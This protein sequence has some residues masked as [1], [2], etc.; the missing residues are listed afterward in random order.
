MK[1]ILL[2]WGAILGLTCMLSA[3]ETVELTLDVFVTAV[4]ANGGIYD[5]AETHPGK[6]VTVAIDPATVTGAPSRVERGGKYP[7]YAYSVQYPRFET[8]ETI[9]ISNVTFVFKTTQ[10]TYTLLNEK[11]DAGVL[12]G[13]LQ[14]LVANAN[15]T[16]TLTNCLFDDVAVSVYGISGS[17]GGLASFT[18]TGCTFKNTGGSAYALKDVN[19]TG[20]GSSVSITGCVFDNVPSGGILLN[21]AAETIA[22][23]DN[24][25]SGVTGAS[26]KEDAAIQFAKGVDFSN[27]TFAIKGNT[28][29]GGAFL[30]LDAQLPS[31]ALQTIIAGNT[32]EK[33]YT[34][35]S[36]PGAWA[37][38]SVT[39][40]YDEAK[41]AYEISSPEELAGLA[42][43]VNA[44]NTFKGKTVNLKASIDLGG[45]EWTPIGNGTRLATLA[46]GGKFEG[47]FN[48]GYKTIS[49]LTITQGQA[50]SSV[51]LF[52]NLS[53]GTVK[54]LYLENVAIDVP[55]EQVG[56]AVGLLVNGATVQSV[57]VRSGSVK[58]AE[59]TGGIVGRMV[60][61]GTVASCTN[62]GAAVSSGKN[63]GG[64]V[65]AAYYD[66]KGMAVKSCTNKG[67]VTGGVC[68]GGIV[69]F[70]VADVESCANSGAV[71]GSGNG[72]GGIVGEQQNAGSV[73]GS[74]N[75]GA[76]KGTAYVGG[77]VGW[78]R[79][80]GADSA[81]P[82][83]TAVAVTGNANSGA[84]E[85]SG[86]SVGGIVGSLYE[87][88]TVSGNT[89]TAAT[90]SGSGNVAGLVG[91]IYNGAEET[92][93]LGNYSTTS[94]LAFVNGAGKRVTLN[95]SSAAGDDIEVAS[96][97][98]LKAFR[99]LVNVGV[100]FAGK[101]VT[102]TAD[103]DLGNEEWK[104]IGKTGASFRGTF[105][106]NGK[107]VSNLET[108]DETLTNAGLFG[109]MDAPAAIKGLTVRNA[110]VSGKASVGALIGCA[111]TG[112][113]EDCHVAGAVSVTG[114]YK[115]GGL[116]G[117]GYADIVG[118][119][120]KGTAKAPITVT[121]SFLAADFEGDNVG[122]LVGFRGEG[123]GI[124]TI[125]CEVAY[126]TASG[127]RKVGGLIGSAFQDNVVR[128]GSVAN[129]TVVCNATQTYAQD[130][131]KT[132]GFG[133]LVG[134]YTAS[135]SNDGELAGCS[136]S[137]V[138][139]D[140]PAYADGVEPSM[141]VL[142][143]G[144]RGTDN[145]LP[146]AD[147]LAV[148]DNT[149][150]GTN[151]GANNGYL[152][153]YVAAIG[154]RKYLSLLD[155]LSAAKAG[156]T[157][158]VLADVT[159]PALSKDEAETSG[160]RDI[161]I[162]G[163]T[164]D[165]NGKAVTCPHMAF[166]LCGTDFT[167]KNGTLIAG[168]GANYALFIGGEPTT[169]NVTV[170]AVSMQGG[171][172]IYN[173]AGVT[174]RGGQATVAAQK[175]YAVW[176]DNDVSDVT[177]E[178]GF[179]VAA[180]EG[181]GEGLVVRVSDAYAGAES[182]IR[183]AGGSYSVRPDDR[184]C[185][186]AEGFV[187][188]PNADGTYRVDEGEYAAQVGDV[189]Y[190]TL[191][192]AMDAA[193]AAEPAPTVTLL[194]DVA[195]EGPVTLTAD[196]TLDLAGH[197]LYAKDGETPAFTADSEVTLTM[198]P[199][200]GGKLIAAAQ[201]KDATKV[202]ISG[203]E[204]VAATKWTDEGAYDEAYHA[205][206]QKMYEEGETF[207]DP[208]AP[209]TIATAGELAALCRFSN[210][211]N[212]EGEQVSMA[213]TADID[214]AG[215][216]WEPI[217]AF[218]GTFDGRTFTIANMA[219]KDAETNGGLFGTLEG[220][221]YGLRLKGASVS[222]KEG[223]ISGRYYTLRGGT[224]AGTLAG[225]VA[226]VSVEDASV[227]GVAPVANL[228]QEPAALGGIVGVAKL[229]SK[230]TDCAV[231]ATV[232][233]PE[234]ASKPIA[235]GAFVGA[236]EKDV[237]LSNGISL[238]MAP[239]EATLAKVTFDNVY[240]RNAE[241]RF[242]RYAT[243]D[244]A[245]AAET[246]GETAQLN[247]IGWLLNG[248]KTEKA[249]TVWRVDSNEAPSALL[250]FE[251][252]K[253][254]VVPDVERYLT[255]NGADCFANGHDATVAMK[256]AEDTLAAV[257]S[258]R[259]DDYLVSEELTLGADA[260]VYPGKEDG[261]A[262]EVAT[263]T[264]ANLATASVDLR[265]VAAV[266][267]N[268]PGT[269]TLASAEIPA[270]QTAALRQGMTLKVPGGVTLAV[271]GAVEVEAG[272]A[273]VGSDGTSLLDIREG[274]AVTGEATGLSAWDGR[275]WAAAMVRSGDAYYASVNAALAALPEGAAVPL[276]SAAAAAG[277]VKAATAG[278]EKVG[279][280]AFAVADTLGG[281]FTVT[282]S[283]LVYDYALGVGGLTVKPDAEGSL[284]VG[285]RVALEEGGRPV[286]GTRELAGR[287]LTVTSELNGE[288]QTFEVKNPIFTDGVCTVTF[289][290]ERMGEGTNRLTVSV[291]KEPSASAP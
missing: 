278:A 33:L 251:A 113:L 111:A 228:W 203:L 88:G 82:T 280:E 193:A 83:K 136:V 105:D 56:G 15:A 139:F 119:S 128:G 127:S 134:L 288:T 155:A 207:N 216:D 131:R 4:E 66:N 71:T 196:A 270:G 241:G 215:L 213:L 90:V 44:G 180:K 204:P 231:T 290:Y 121:G 271:S 35:S 22:I 189:K 94:G 194:R 248:R 37:G 104:P 27:T 177:I 101:T 102:L 230:L 135:G 36:T 41:D 201:S 240:A 257:L 73:K 256:E 60:S 91:E 232:A 52:G 265:G 55:A 171:V 7:D 93:V 19:V 185:T 172:N 268:G 223:K 261:S 234:G 126:V 11:Y 100:A 211:G 195:L 30:R 254:K 103:I 75:S 114:S 31:D 115:V 199:G 258:V 43:L 76:V 146:P 110:T 20:V 25:F 243:K 159:V 10:E 279:A 28:I 163:M 192:E 77:I 46:M 140:A 68:T 233:A 85:G 179:F 144:L 164:L 181:A 259:R 242:V 161:D 219:V 229:G 267:L 26:F 80:S 81:Y 32:A 253:V 237:T 235:T 50:S 24:T 147:T 133:G 262:V 249:V 170:E 109:R 198:V 65:G 272:S 285:V 184:Y 64:I 108:V 117:E 97:D 149:V 174:L 137:D 255:R 78:V 225:T 112:T 175:Y 252:E 238:G 206:L 8:L 18:A 281:A 87:K 284:V 2:A 239:N 190:A 9:D 151:V 86:G 29:K 17:T 42:Q 188:Y 247:G 59:G 143:G 208:E 95:F 212:F 152:I 226:N 123:E 70:S 250:P 200:E 289:P 57:T 217:K 125:G 202:I 245:L 221:A 150:S 153:P 167:V 197:A 63:T 74:T 264:F 277:R 53:G 12:H 283:A 107:T 169:R 62:S 236:A 34:S 286:A 122:G 67:T 132:L 138:T 263:L 282:E 269:A 145:P 260:V 61:Q 13:Q 49:N 166:V 1:R 54:G 69:G 99:D 106:G 40:W 120:V 218:T 222:V 124:E 47:T 214:L 182:P 162:S 154:E 224:L 246:L 210:E 141:G 84:V 176:C 72:T 274:G 21:K 276:L 45:R 266:T 129:A 38:K 48:G 244:G 130:N 23:S 205:K 156:D 178:S 116:A 183:L 98:E 191:Q 6:T 227:S 275:K 287:T 158:T 51:G 58:G 186:Y 89:N 220:E 157:V 118:C 5:G 14:L 79:Y 273:L 160:E 187:P 3:Q 39:G 16:V 173:A 142:T 148:A 209:L 168:E 165:L 291:S 92:V 96:L